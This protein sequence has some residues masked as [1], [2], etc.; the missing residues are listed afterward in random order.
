MSNSIYI[1]G[2]LIWYLN[3]EILSINR[4][5]IEVELSACA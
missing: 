3:H 4:L 2:C 1:I 5:D